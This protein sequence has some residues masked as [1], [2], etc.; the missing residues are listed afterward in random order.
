MLE[1]VTSLQPTSSRFH[2]KNIVNACIERDN[3]FQDF[4]DVLSCFDGDT[5]P[6]QTLIK[7]VK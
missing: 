1:F 7:F 4:L 2:V 3:G 6:Y 5:K